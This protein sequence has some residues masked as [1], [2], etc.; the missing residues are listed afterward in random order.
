ML[1]AQR[2]LIASIAWKAGSWREL[3]GA[4]GPTGACGIY[5]RLAEDAFDIRTVSR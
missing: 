1:Q 3:L 2:R 5:F 4:G